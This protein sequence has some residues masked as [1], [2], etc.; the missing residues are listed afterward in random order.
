MEVTANKLFNYIRCRRFAAL[1]DAN[2]ATDPFKNNDYYQKAVSKFKDIF[3]G[4]NYHDKLSYVKDINYTYDFHHDFTL[5]EDYDFIFNDE[6]IYV[7][8]PESSKEFLKLKYKHN[9][10]SYQLFK[11]N[12][13][14]NYQLDKKGKN[15]VNYQQKLNKLYAKNEITG[16]VILKFAFMQYL[17]KNIFPNK[18]FNMYFIFINEDYTH[19]GVAYTNKL[20]HVFDFSNLEDLDNK[21]E[22]SLFRMI[23]HIELNDFTP[24]ELVRNA[25]LRGKALECKFVNFCYS[26]L[27]KQN[28]IFDYFDPHLGFKEKLKK[29]YVHH[30]TYELLNE[31]Y[32][33]M[34]DIPLEWLQNK[35][36]LMQRYCLDNNVSYINK[37]KIKLMLSYLKSPLIYL[38]LSY[39]PIIIPKFKHEKP[40]EDITFQYSLYVDNEN[41]LSLSSKSF[42]NK[43]KETRNDNRIDFA[44]KFV[45]EL[46]KYDS[47][48]IVYNKPKILRILEGS[49]LIFPHLK[50][51]LQ[52]IINR[53][54]DILDIL[55]IDAKFLR[56]LKVKNLDL[57]TYNFYDNRLSG[58]Y[59]RDKLAKVFGFDKINQL[60]IHDDK[61]E[62]KTFRL[63]NDQ[64]ETTKENLKSEMILY[65]QHKAYLLYKIIT[66]LREMISS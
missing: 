2:T 28:S 35:N 29:T 23:N 59:S 56:D 14:G 64:D 5:S 50:N 51:K 11:K 34:E 63:F 10:H 3:L 15:S 52:M 43:F 32:L 21:I 49:K 39:M 66:G 7:I 30:D 24:C 22:I 46:I 65:S 37:E 9:S 18:N 38:D 62:Y 6:D 8:I 31:G 47:S 12:S 13:Q 17:Y 36:R 61:T 48:I 20:Y 4:L 19:D 57:S 45:N 26:H 16:Q 1:N 41:E 44:E 60:P 40:F 54:V 25:C 58:S 42:I 33:K 55:K 27:P 53:V